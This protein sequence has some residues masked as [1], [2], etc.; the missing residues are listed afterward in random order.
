M[1]TAWRVAL[2]AL[3]AFLA[4]SVYHA[5]S[6]WAWSG[7]LRTPPGAP[8]ITLDYHCGAPWGSGY[9][10][11]PTSTL[12]PLISK[13]CGQRTNYQIVTAIDVLVGV[14]GVAVVGTWARARAR[15]VDA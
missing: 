14:F 10:H 5:V 7:Q 4:F 13:P 8:T 11:G 12:A 9:V 1:S 15:H 3:I 2:V 6:P